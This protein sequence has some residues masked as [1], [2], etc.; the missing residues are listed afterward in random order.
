MAWYN[1]GWRFR[2][3]VTVNNVGGTSSTISFIEDLPDDDHFWENVRSDGDDIIATGPDGVTL[4]PFNLNGYNRNNKA[5]TLRAHIAD[6]YDD[7]NNLVW[8]YYG[9]ADQTTS[10]QGSPTLTNS[11]AAQISDA[12]PGRYRIQAQPERD[13]ATI[14]RVKVQKSAAESL[15]LWWD[16]SAYLQKSRRR[17][18]G[19][20]RREEIAAASFSVLK[21]SSNTPTEDTNLFE[22]AVVFAAPHWVGTV[23]KAGDT[24]IDYVMSLTV[25]T[26]G[27]DWNK[28]INPRAL[29][30]VR[31]VLYPTT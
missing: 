30:R 11:K 6:P 20:D 10:L 12:L 7:A 15:L 22:S 9:N 26:T 23:V 1:S 29:L 16:L 21:D 17:I 27:G 25:T 24:G 28:V 14:P 19:R 5:G 2:R 31:D 13:G 4:L 18:N 3:P 8:L